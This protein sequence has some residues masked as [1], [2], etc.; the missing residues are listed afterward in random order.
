MARPEVITVENVEKCAALYAC[1]GDLGALAESYGVKADTLR[2]RIVRRYGALPARLPSPACT[3]WLG[4]AARLLDAMALE[5]NCNAFRSMAGA[6]RDA[7]AAA[8]AQTQT[9]R[10]VASGRQPPPAGS[11]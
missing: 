9:I 7:I 6:I 10:D 11:R 2:R 3:G 1:G 8:D 4:A 5:S